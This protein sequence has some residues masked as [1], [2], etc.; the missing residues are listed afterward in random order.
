MKMRRVSRIAML[1]AAI[2]LGACSAS[3]PGREAIAD[4]CVA[5]GEKPEVCDCFAEESSRRLDKPMF[6][7]V[8]L[9]A[10]GRDSEAETRIRALGPER[11]GA[12]ST[13][14]RGIIRGCGGEAYLIA[15]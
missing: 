7:L 8:V 15:G 13:I 14:V 5:G 6:E 2:A 11:Q 12:F 3:G 9:G 4:R 1:L 10:Q